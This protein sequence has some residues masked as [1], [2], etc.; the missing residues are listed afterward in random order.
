M[1]GLVQ[2]YT[3]CKCVET[4]DVGHFTEGDETYLYCKVCN[5]TNLTEK[6]EN[7]VPCYHEVTEAEHERLLM[8][9]GDWDEEDEVEGF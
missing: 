1:F 2:L 7:G 3:G 9:S 5:G 8:E 4:W 6:K